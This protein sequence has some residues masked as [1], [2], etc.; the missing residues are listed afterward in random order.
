[1]KRKYVKRTETIPDDTPSMADAVRWL[2]D[3]GRRTSGLPGA[4]TIRRGLDF[5]TPIALALE[6]LDSGGNLR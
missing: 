4:I 1:M 2:A 3:L 5:I 6:V